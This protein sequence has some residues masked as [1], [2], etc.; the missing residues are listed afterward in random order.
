MMHCLCCAHHKRGT[1]HVAHYLCVEAGGNSFSS[2]HIA[3]RRG[4][5]RRNCT[6]QTNPTRGLELELSLGLK[7]KLSM[8][9]CLRGHTALKEGEMEGDG[10]WG[11]G[12][13]STF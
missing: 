4:E 6:P 11:L 10:T 3:Y 1:W 5:P 12:L 2:A 7:C 13:L 8:P 9:P